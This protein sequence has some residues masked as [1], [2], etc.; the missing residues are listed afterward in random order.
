MPLKFPLVHTEPGAM[1]RA[2]TIFQLRGRRW[3][4]IALCVLSALAFSSAAAAAGR[5]GV[6]KVQASCAGDT[7]S[8]RVRLNAASPVKA[9][10][11]LWSKSGAKARFRPTGKAR[12]FTA[13]ASRWYPVRFNISRLDAYAYRVDASKKVRS[14][15]ILSASCAPG[16][17]IP[18]APFALLLPISLLIGIGLPVYLSRR[19]RSAVIQP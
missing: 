10:I 7:I 18:D 6:T 3:C 4:V 13:R 11:E 16:H 12:T 14:R 17:Q 9:R 19:R 2:A 5:G 8:A 1:T 15:W